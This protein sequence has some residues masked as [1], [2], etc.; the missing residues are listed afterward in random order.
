MVCIISFSGNDTPS[1]H[2]TPVFSSS[3]HWVCCVC[4][5]VALLQSTLLNCK[6]RV[7]VLALQTNKKKPKTVAHGVILSYLIKLNSLSEKRKKESSE[8]S[9][10]AIADCLTL[11]HYQFTEC[12]N[13]LSELG[14]FVKH[15]TC[16]LWLSCK[17][18][19]SVFDILSFTL[20]VVS[21]FISLVREY[22]NYS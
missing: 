9:I 3:A 10:A 7:N 5:L 17:A 22:Q 18:L 11:A 19:N 8:I 21:S 14:V 15:F 20:F 16:S 13:R 4:P 1:V 2:D 12:L 6:Q